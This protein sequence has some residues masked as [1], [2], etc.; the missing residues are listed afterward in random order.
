MAMTGRERLLAVLH[1]QPTDRLA[2]TTLVDNATLEGLPEELRGQGGLAFYRHLGCGIFLLDCWNLPY[3]FGSPVLVWPEWVETETVRQGDTTTEHYRTPGRT[4]SRVWRRS[5][6]VRYLLQSV[7]DV[8]L[9]RQ[10]WAGARYLSG[11]DAPVAAR[12]A[13]D[14]GAD[15][16]ATRFW[17]PSAIPRL[18][19]LDAGMEGFYYLLQD[20]CA[21]VEALIQA[22]HEREVEA[23]SLL[24]Q[25]PC[26]A[27]T[28]VENT[29]TLYI[30]PTVYRRYNKPAICDFVDLVHAA[31]KV[32]LV[33]MCGHVRELL[34]DFCD[35]GM[36]GIHALT[37]PPTGNT[38]WELALDVM[39]EDTVI[40]GVLDP[41]IFAA[42]PV[43]Q[44]GPALDQLYTPRLRRAHFVL[45]PAADGIAVPQERFE[46]VAL[47]MKR[48]GER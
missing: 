26:E 35:T 38:P 33:H 48:N 5:H 11:D 47:W 27:I 43:E 40:I 46:A 18:L 37:P 7:A 6:P 21:E 10:M 22:M 3:H 36:D 45:C 13:T 17:G 31:G 9:Y 19:E 20:H 32:A 4:L 16:I 14:L 25:S 30:S 12:L 24:A 15:G 1:R 41:T 8:D 2:W 42:G 29:S 34:A 39:G 44:I 28:L 23:F